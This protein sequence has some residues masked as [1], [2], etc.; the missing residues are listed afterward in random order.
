M[1][2]VCQLPYKGVEEKSKL[3]NQ[4]RGTLE[5]KRKKTRSYMAILQN[6]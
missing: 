4:D 3:S 5:E 2:R 1:G 6:I